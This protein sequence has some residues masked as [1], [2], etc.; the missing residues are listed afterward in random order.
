MPKFFP[1]PSPKPEEVTKEEER[2]TPSPSPS[3]FFT[4]EAP[5]DE[6]VFSESE[7]LVSGKTNPGTLVA[8]V[9]PTDEAVVE[10]D[11][12]GKFEEELLL[13]EGAN[14]VSV[15]AYQEEGEET[16]LITVF[17]TKEEI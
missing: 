1:K 4:L 10:A 5:Q 17:Y 13:E 12:E 7:I 9:S 8:I 2:L 14:E 6:T 3:L 15:T 16:K 11:A